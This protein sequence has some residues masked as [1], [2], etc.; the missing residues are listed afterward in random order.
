MTSTKGSVPRGMLLDGSG[1]LLS[2]RLSSLRLGYEVDR[3]AAE[4][5]LQTIGDVIS[6]L[7]GR[8][9]YCIHTCSMYIMWQKCWRRLRECS[10]GVVCIICMCRWQSR[11]THG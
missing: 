6:Q 8:A 5:N 7:R 1:A 10:H 9:L 2:V 4:H 3:Y 11:C